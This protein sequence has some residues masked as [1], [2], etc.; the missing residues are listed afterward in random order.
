MQPEKVSECE[1][2]DRN[3][4]GSSCEEMN[5]VPKDVNFVKKSLHYMNSPKHFVTLKDKMLE[6]KT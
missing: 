4:K 6:A 5:D 3:E 1:L 2:V